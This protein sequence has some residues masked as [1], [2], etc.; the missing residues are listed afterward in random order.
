LARALRVRRRGDPELPQAVGVFLPFG[1][2]RDP[3]ALGPDL[4]RGD[5]LREPVRDAL[6]TIE[7][8]DPIPRLRWIRLSL[9]ELLGL[10]PHDLVDQ[11]ALGVPVVV[12]G[13]APL[14]RPSMAVAI[15]GL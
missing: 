4:N 2:V 12:D 3:L 13:T 15:G 9:E 6:H 14:S 1:D 10:E 11:I 5:Q 7:V 8:P